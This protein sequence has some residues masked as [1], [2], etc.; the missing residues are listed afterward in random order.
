MSLQERL[1]RVVSEEQ[2]GDN[3]VTIGIG[4]NAHRKSSVVSCG[5]I[6]DKKNI[7]KS[8]SSLIEPNAL[9]EAQSASLIVA[10]VRTIV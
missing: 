1:I 2:M 7:P 4:N 3:E 6:T 8:S 5:M 9:G 10:Q